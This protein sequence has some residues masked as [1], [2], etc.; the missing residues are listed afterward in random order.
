Q[1]LEMKVAIHLKTGERQRMTN[2]HN[3]TFTNRRYLDAIANHV[4][5]FDGA[6]GTNIQRLNLKPEDYGGERYNGLNEHL[7]LTKTEV[8]EN[9]HASFLEVGSEVVE[10]CT[11]RGNRLTLGEF[12]VAE[13]TLEINRTA[14][15]IARR[16]CDR[17]ERETGIPRFVAGSMGPTGK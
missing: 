10:T 3:Y 13:K 15:Q 11:F 14:A 1:Q 7:V 2:R 8:I 5:L 12:G 4:V 17:F 9:L 16:V 6:T